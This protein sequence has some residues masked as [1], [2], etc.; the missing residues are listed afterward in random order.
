MRVA[1]SA[2]AWASSPPRWPRSSVPRATCRPSSPGSTARPDAPRCQQA[3]VAERV[4]LTQPP[5]GTGLVPPLDF[6][7]AFWMCTRCPTRAFSHRDQRRARARRPGVIAEPKLHV[8]QRSSRHVEV[9]RRWASTSRRG[10]RELQ[11]SVCCRR[12]RRR[13]SWG[14]V[15]LTYDQRRPMG[16]GQ[17]TH[18]GV[19]RRPGSPRPG[20]A[21][22]ARKGVAMAGKPARRSHHTTPSVPTGGADSR[23]RPQRFE[24]PARRR[25]LR[26]IVASSAA[27]RG[28]QARPALR[29]AS[30]SVGGDWAE[31]AES[32]LQKL[33]NR[34]TDEAR[35]PRG[36]HRQ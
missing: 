36:L 2:A 22:R 20:D 10:Q 16:F 6:V 11:R 28:A 26:Q 13:L 21:C 4:S 25:G 14:R 30:G 33:V 35:T 15:A 27:R 34:L 12:E 18:D 7:L 3:G 24:S 5:R 9:S 1:I 23:G 31:L 17:R 8:R 32:E 19:W 29:G